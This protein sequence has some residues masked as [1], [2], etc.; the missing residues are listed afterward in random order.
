MPYTFKNFRIGTRYHLK[1]F[2][3]VVGRGRDEDDC[4]MNHERFDTL[5]PR[6]EIEM[7]FNMIDE[8]FVVIRP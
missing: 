4:R 3:T 2:K 6:Q 1:F 8:G 7:F 5:Y